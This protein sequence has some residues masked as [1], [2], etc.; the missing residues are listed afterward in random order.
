MTVAASGTVTATHIKA[1]LMLLAKLHTNYQR[2]LHIVL[3]R[4]SGGMPSAVVVGSP[5]LLAQAR[6][7]SIRRLLQMLA[8]MF[9]NSDPL[10]TGLILNDHAQAVSYFIYPTYLVVQSMQRLLHSWFQAR[11]GSVSFL[12]SYMLMMSFCIWGSELGLVLNLGLYSLSFF[13][14]A[15]Q[16]SKQRMVSQRIEW[17]EG[18]SHRTFKLPHLQKIQQNLRD[19]GILVKKFHVF[20]T[21]GKEVV[22]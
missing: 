8:D 15:H 5:V 10:R 22:S 18:N 12:D 2:R 7:H 14:L 20:Q 13:S 3:G 19:Q 1:K 4:D 16:V 17:I 11:L 21:P 9:R 6:R